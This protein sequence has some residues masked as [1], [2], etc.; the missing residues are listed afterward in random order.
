[1]K[2]TL[3]ILFVVLALL[4]GVG[5]FVLPTTI[6]WGDYIQEV[7]A[8]VKKTTGR[9]L[10]VQGTPVFTMRPVP[11]LKLGKLTMTNAAGASMPNMMTA[12]GAEIQFDAGALFR[13][14]T[15]IK[16]IT[17][18]S[19]KFFVEDL[20]DGTPNWQPSF[21]LR[22]PSGKG[23]GF[24]SLLVKNGSAFV[25]PDKYSEPH[26]WNN[27]NAEV[28]A[29]TMQGPFFLEG[30]LSA[31][32]TTFGFSMKI[33]KI[34]PG[35]SPEFN[36]RLLNSP[37][38]ATF[39]FSGG[40]GVKDG[41]KDALEGNVN[42]EIRKTAEAV[43]ILFPDAKA[44]P[45]DLFQ[46]L[47]GNLTVKSKSSERLTELSEVLFKFGTSSA[48]GKIEIKKLS[49]E[50]KA[51]RETAAPAGEEQEDEE[52]IFLIDPDR[53]N[54]R[55]SLKGLPEKLNIHENALPKIIKGDFLFSQFAADP[56]VKNAGA[57][58]D[59]IAETGGKT[60]SDDEFDV[61]VAFDT[62]ELHGDLIRQMKMS[63][64]EDAKGIKISDIQ[65]S[66]P[67]NADVT[68]N[69]VLETSGK[70]PVFVGEGRIEADNVGALLKWGG[71]KIPEEIPQNLLRSFLM[72]AKFKAAKNGV[73][74]ENADISLDQMKVK[75]AMSL[76]LAGR[77][78]VS[79]A[80]EAN[81]LNFDAYFPKSRE[82]ALKK[83]EEFFSQNLTLPQKIRRIFDGLAFVNDTDIALNLKSGAFSWGSVKADSVEANLSAVRGYMQIKN[84]A[85]KN[86][87]TASFNGAGG[88][89]GFGG[90]P[91]FKSFVFNLDTK[92]LGDFMKATGF[93]LPKEITRS[94]ALNLST[95]TEGTLD[96]FDFGADVK[97]GEFSAVATGTVEN[98]M[99]EPDYT[100]QL[101]LK[102]E[103]LRNFARLFTDKYRP[104]LANPGVFSGNFHVVKNGNVWQL[105]DIDF[106][107]GENG[108][109]GSAKYDASA[110]MPKLSASF[111]AERLEPFS[112]L[113]RLNFLD[114]AAVNTATAR[115]PENK[116][117]KKQI[118][119]FSPL[120]KKR[121]FQKVP[122]DFSFLGG[123]E[124][125]VQLKAETLVFDKLVLNDVDL[126]LNLSPAEMKLDIRHA[127]WE[128]A[129]V[130]SIA[131]F[132][133]EPEKSPSVVWRTRLA[134]LPAA[135]NA[136]GAKGLDL[137]YTAVTA[138]INLS[139]QGK[140]ANDMIEALLGGGRI[141]FSNPVF[142]GVDFAGMENALSA[143]GQ[144][145]RDAL[146]NSAKTGRTALSELYA[147][148]RVA[149]GEVKFDP[150][151]LS[152]DQKKSQISSLA[153]DYKKRRVNYLISVNL[154][155]PSMLDVVRDRM[156]EFEI[157]GVGEVGAVSVSNNASELADTMASIEEE[158]EAQ[159]KAEEE[160]QLKEEEERQKSIQ[161]ELNEEYSRM[162]N[163]LLIRI[164]DLKSKINNLKAYEGK[165][166]SIRK[167]MVPLENI[168][169]S[170]N[171]FLEDI[172]KEKA[173]TKTQ[174][175]LD[176]RRLNLQNDILSKFSETE[177]TYISA[178]LEGARGLIENQQIQARK[179]LEQ[180]AKMKASYPEEKEISSAADLITQEIKKLDDFTAKAKTTDSYHPL[181]LMVADADV[182][183]NKIKTSFETAEQAAK[184]KAE[185]IKAKEEAKRK[186]EEE[187]KKAEEA[188][189]K[190]EEE[191]K[192]KAEEERSRTIF[193]TDGIRSSSND[194]ERDENKSDKKPTF[195]L[196]PETQPADNRGDEAQKT[197]K[198][199]IIR[200]R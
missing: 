20:Q 98:V 165:V 67:G 152:H 100:M 143:R 58:I 97:M 154:T 185:E 33:E 177:K 52:E 79:V 47:V 164:D 106:N 86:F 71:L 113:P 84:F 129:N 123:Y 191:A 76:R 38:E 110:K 46:P 124:A 40:Y 27:I 194:I 43:K 29:D 45:A 126:G 171:K 138:D 65:A 122:L 199:V 168:L 162:E 59:F 174:E 61:K 151:T 92:R 173:G 111:T 155:T 7:S 157:N 14:Q 96:A 37:A 190:A 25:R 89:S 17:L 16:K 125:D 23:V 183:F 104:A 145:A 131:T 101:S 176:R 127:T 181:T 121:E 146:L 68:G 200:R 26:S 144:A 189:K 81:E 169:K 9:S 21:L 175:A 170:W 163:E 32:S 80:A 167:Y 196:I 114:P 70:Q 62:A 117:G 63:F 195:K 56:W 34:E 132:K 85:V 4:G 82:E 187:R 166:Y 18:F 184:K 135:S 93:S 172:Q 31:L 2:K 73:V 115:D 141:S 57:L 90:T 150:I 30:N 134:N 180:T 22:A 83:H 137:S 88:L 3:I 94:D 198:T 133:I 78:A 139:S 10:V 28:F 136:F 48:T 108:L 107:V 95:E 142:E 74:L 91:V 112:F 182:V 35:K 36:L 12:E 44:L 161:L 13:R 105:S 5:Y 75:G 156:P 109:A 128:G 1:M 15:K 192:R 153:Y 42:F 55:F 8:S 50:E 54:E 60:A 69:I 118:N 119:V 39:S 66:M 120:L 99:N 158:A 6:N 147:P 179:W 148:Y 140:T 116:N 53:P 130:V 49:P 11:V 197:K 102:H 103:N 160:R 19:P 193:R 72:S 87:A 77:K 186:A 24:E 188:A 149:N 64:S 178:Q 51:A 41:D 159:R